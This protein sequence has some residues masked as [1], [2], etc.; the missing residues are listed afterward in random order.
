MSTSILGL[1]HELPP[2]KAVEDTKRPTVS[3]PC[4]PSDLALAASQRALAEA[5]WTPDSVEMLVFATMTPDVSFPG[6]GCFLQEKLGGGTVGAMDIRGQCAG[7]LMGLAVANDLIESGKYERVLLAGAEVHSSAMDRSE[8]GLPI[9]T[10]Y[11]D[12]G[13][14]AAI[15]G[16][17]GIADVSAVMCGSDGRHYARFW[18]E[19]PASKHYPDRISIEDFEA[20]KHFLQIDRDHVATFG[21]EKL[22]ET[23]RKTLATRDL[24]VDQVDLLIV[25]HVFPEVAED[26]ARALGLGDDRFVV[27]G[28]EHGHLTAA[29]LP[30]A[31]NEA[32]EA[33]RIGSGAK[34]GLAACGAGYAWGAALLEFA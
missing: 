12:G 10:L 31:L 11:G 20:G 21:R 7:Y 6:A 28:S 4:G 14:V 24:P 18:C 8:S 13:A 9:R 17:P 27:A 1:G 3:A 2:V 33:G 34:V 25:S 5:G 30:V 19:Y 15:S 16:G 29:S 26:A 32:R 23:V 22:P